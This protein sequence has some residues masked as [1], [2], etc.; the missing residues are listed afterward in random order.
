A[1]FLLL[2]GVERLAL[3]FGRQ[4]LRVRP[5]LGELGGNL[6]AA[7]A[8][9]QEVVRRAEALVLQQPGGAGAA[10]VLE[11]GLH[12]EDFLHRDRE[13]LR[14]RDAELLLR[15]DLMRRLVQR[16]DRRQT[17]GLQLLRALPDRRP[18]E[19]G[20][21]E[22]RRDRLVLADALVGVAKTLP[23]ELERRLPVRSLE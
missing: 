16:H 2:G 17:L 19:H 3:L 10:A 12:R 15:D 8:Q 20:E 1:A 5:P 6:A 22:H 9:Q 7:G 23:D 11:A 14:D 18:Q 21:Q 13:A 4:F